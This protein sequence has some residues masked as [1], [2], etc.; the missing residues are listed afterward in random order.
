MFFCCNLGKRSTKSRNVASLVFE[1]LCLLPRSGQNLETRT[2]QTWLYAYM[3]RYQ[4]VN[5]SDIS[6]YPSSD[7]YMNV[8]T[9]HRSLCSHVG[10]ESNRL[11]ET[12]IN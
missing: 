2:F 12:E 5:K 8:A 10:R 4:T 3:C 11:N 9:L 1:T 7:L 6:E